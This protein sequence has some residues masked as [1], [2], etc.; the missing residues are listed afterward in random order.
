MPW[1]LPPFRPMPPPWVF[2]QELSIRLRA[3]NV[4]PVSEVRRFAVAS[5]PAD[6]VPRAIDVGGKIIN[7]G[8]QHRGA[9]SR[10]AVGIVPQLAVRGVVEKS[11][12]APGAETSP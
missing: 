4:R 9:A 1:S 11:A 6:E 8:D 12:S 3:Q 2:R 7:R 10:L 5:R